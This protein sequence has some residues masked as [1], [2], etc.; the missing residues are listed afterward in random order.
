MDNRIFNRYGVISVDYDIVVWIFIYV[1]LGVDYFIKYTFIDGKN[2]LEIGDQLA[3]D[4]WYFRLWYLCIIVVNWYD[5]CFASTL[6]IWTNF[7]FFKFSIMWILRTTINNY[8]KKIVS[9]YLKFHKKNVSPA[10]LLMYV[11]RV[12][13][14]SGGCQAIGLQPITDIFFTFTLNTECGIRFINGDIDTHTTP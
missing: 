6:G 12:D 13:L 3:T 8:Y 9:W 2:F 5:F 7:T 11:V 14:G 10:F 4:Y 1:R